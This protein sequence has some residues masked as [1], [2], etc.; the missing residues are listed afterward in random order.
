MNKHNKKKVYMYKSRIT[1]KVQFK[2]MSMRS[3]KVLEVRELAGR[4]EGFSS[5]MRHSPLL[6]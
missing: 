3:D 2:A 5:K 1:S 4:M 6:P